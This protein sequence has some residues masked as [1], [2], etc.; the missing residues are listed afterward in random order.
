MRPPV[1]G[2]TQRTFPA[3]AEPRYRC[4][5]RIS[6]ARAQC[7]L[8]SCDL[9]AR[10][11]RSR[12]P[13]RPHKNC[14]VQATNATV[15]LVRLNAGDGMRLHVLKELHGA[16]KTI[17]REDWP[18]EVAL[19]TAQSHPFILQV[20]EVL[21]DVPMG[22]LGMVTEY[23][24]QGDLFSLLI[25]LRRRGERVP[26]SQLLSWLAQLCLALSHLHRQRIIHRDVKTSNIFV[27]ADRTLKLGD[28]GFAKALQAQ[29]DALVSRVG[30]PFYMSPEICKN[31]P[32]GTP[33]DVWSMGCVLYEMLCLQPAFYAENMMLVLDRICAAAYDAPP[34]DACSEDIRQLLSEMLQ[35]DPDARPAT[36]EVLQHPALRPV[37]QQLE[38]PT[39]PPPALAQRL[40]ADSAEA[41]E[42]RD[43][44]RAARAREQAL[45]AETERRR[46]EEQAQGGF[47]MMGLS[48]LA[49]RG[50][51]LLGFSVGLGFSRQGGMDAEG[52]FGMHAAPTPSQKAASARAEAEAALGAMRRQLEG[53]LGAPALRA[54]LGVALEALPMEA[55]PEAAWATWESER[56]AALAALLRAPTAGSEA[57]L[58]DGEGSSG[59]GG[60]SGVSGSSGGSGGSRGGGEAVADP[61]ARAVLALA[62]WQAQA[63]ESVAAAA[64]PQGAIPP[65]DAGAATDRSTDVFSVRGAWTFLGR[66][67]SPPRVS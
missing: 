21:H 27:G 6:Q 2:A 52:D 45:A 51:S 30:S 14:F 26:E 42:M 67:E 44:V 50:L 4:I 13:S 53:T 35:L 54:A 8:N 58:K 29:Q 3:W 46:L 37:L 25:E 22:E 20:V 34:P 43:A 62:L 56:L 66:S 47:N 38:P 19:L 64:R 31:L 57:A 11:G 9:C 60:S 48:R 10:G 12:K 16:E 17:S 39:P 1:G 41:E 7:A 23:C 61:L 5:K 65:I 15:W 36:Q 59:V 40:S 32:Y 18:H 63:D 55:A 49:E 28:F 33:S 24:D